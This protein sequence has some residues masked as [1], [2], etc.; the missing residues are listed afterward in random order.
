MTKDAYDRDMDAYA[1]FRH[2]QNVMDVVKL[3]GL[4]AAI[5]AVVAL[6]ALALHALLW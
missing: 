6:F 2:R 5:C 3:L 1:R 4:F